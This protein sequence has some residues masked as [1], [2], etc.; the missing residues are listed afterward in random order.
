[1]FRLFHL[2][3]VIDPL[4]PNLIHILEQLR[5]EDGMWSKYGLRSLSKKDALYGQGEDYW[6]GA[7]WMNMNYLAV[8]ALHDYKSFDYDK[9]HQN[10]QNL[11]ETTYKELRENLMR[12]LYGEYKKFGF[13]YENYNGDDGH[14]QRSKPFTGWSS[15]IL[16]IISETYP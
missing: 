13:L 3:Q 9:E 16:N 4:S 2:L 8:K 11:L 7:I 15:L 1:M 12:N 5:D 6:R 10:V 14:G